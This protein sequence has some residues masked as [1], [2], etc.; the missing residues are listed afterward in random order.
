MNEDAFLRA[1]QDDPDDTSRL[2]Y[3]DWLEE[4]GEN[5]RAEFIRVQ[6]A[7]ANLSE[8]DPGRAALA[9]REAAL[10]AKHRAAWL[11]PLPAW[12][13]DG[14]YRFRRGFVDEITATTTQF[15]K[16]AANLLKRVPVRAVR[17][18]GARQHI[19]ALAA[20]PHLARLTSLDLSSND[21]EELEA[22]RLA[23]PP[24]LENL[25]ALRLGRNPLR[26]GG[27]AALAACPRLGRLRV[28]D[29]TNTVVND[30][31]ATALADSPHLANLARLVL[32]TNSLQPW[33]MTPA[34]AAAL[35]RSPHLTNLNELSLRCQE[36]GDKGAAALAASRN[37]VGVRSLDLNNCR[38]GAAG[39]S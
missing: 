13:R 33:C 18:R 11:K 19:E 5:E 27:I 2:V 9:E 32:T 24:Y 1:L 35:A 20:C 25:S 8:D 21:L 26:A 38:L 30:V 10:L 37:L 39:V 31:A 6:C 15:L 3:A 36:I 7:L 34:G 16:G 12:A 29:L 28:L 14:A 22:I 23:A 4:H 17:L